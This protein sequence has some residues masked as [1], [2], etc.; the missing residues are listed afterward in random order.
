[1]KTILVS[2]LLIIVVLAIY[3]AAIGGST[4]MRADVAARGERIGRSIQR[5]D[6]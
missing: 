4:G 3:E 6:P 1:M 5:F 2:V